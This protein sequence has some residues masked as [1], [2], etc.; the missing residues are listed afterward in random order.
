MVTDREIFVEG[1]EDSDFRLDAPRDRNELQPNIQVVV[2]MDNVR[3]DLLKQLRE[4]LMHLLR[5]LRKKETIK[6]WCRE[7]RLIAATAEIREYGR[8]QSI[9]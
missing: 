7:H 1:H 3:I 2:E 6:L 8:A 5:G 9:I 4:F